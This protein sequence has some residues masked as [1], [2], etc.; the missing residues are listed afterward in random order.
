MARATMSPQQIL[1]LAASLPLAGHVVSWRMSGVEIGRTDLESLLKKHQ[2]AW[3]MP[4][5]PPTLKGAFSRAL[6]GWIQAK[7]ALKLA[8]G[9]GGDSD[10]EDVTGS[11]TRERAMIRISSPKG[12]AYTVFAIV[13]EVVDLKKLGFRYG[14]SMRFLLEKATGAVICTTDSTGAA[15]QVSQER[16]IMQEI[17]PYWSRFQVAYV[18][19]D[20]S[21]II[22]SIV[23]SLDPLVL[24]EGGGSYFVPE[25]HR[26]ALDR[27][28]ALVDDLPLV[29]TRKPF[30]TMIPI[31][32]VPAARQ[33]LT[34]AAHA[35]MIDDIEAARKDLERFLSQESGTVKPET[36]A[37]RLEGFKA[38]RA[39]ANLYAGLLGMWVDDIAHGLDTLTNAAKA[40]VTS[41]LMV[42]PTEDAEEGDP[43]RSTAVGGMDSSEQA[44]GGTEPPAAAESNA[45]TAITAASSAPTSAPALRRR[46]ASIVPIDTLQRSARRV[47]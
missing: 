47:A 15:D 25:T 27:L 9:T 46:H 10:D 35:S 41:D 13:G 38:L 45:P 16:V 22:R 20:L 32:D 5:K 21:R 8:R 28:A 14:T 18:S 26:A 42:A 37:A 6:E 33:Q 12:S 4:K 23:E 24:R 19:G 11:G 34:R 31:P 40:V 1:N 36:I 29:G 17:A 30:L 39:R 44:V 43:S 2:F 7:G 3:A